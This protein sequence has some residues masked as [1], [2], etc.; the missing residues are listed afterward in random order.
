MNSG[1]LAE[2]I[3]NLLDARWQKVVLVTDHGWILIPGGLPK[4]ELPEHL[5]EVRK[6]R[7]ARL[8]EGASTEYQVVPWYWNPE[9]RVAVAPGIYCFEAGKE[10]EHGGLSPQ[11]CIVPTITATRNIPTP[12]VR[13]ESLKWRRLRCNIEV[14]GATAGSRIDIR[15]R[16]DDTSTTIVR[17]GKDLDTDGNIS[18][19]VEDEDLE[20]QAAVVVVVGP[21]GTVLFQDSTIVG[22]P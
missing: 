22:D 14:R 10:Y 17:G 1:R 2:R 21:D 11:E 3:T 20:G 18:L 4:A 16:R 15:T 7:C 19:V 9:V 13:I 6:G 12:S 8:K 5:T